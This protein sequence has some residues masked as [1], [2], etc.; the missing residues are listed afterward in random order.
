MDHVPGVTDDRLSEWVQELES[1]VVECSDIPM[2]VIRSIRYYLS[3][4]VSVVVQELRCPGFNARIY[5]TQAAWHPKLQQW[6][7][8]AATATTQYN[9]VFHCSRVLVQWDGTKNS[10]CQRFAGQWEDHSGD[11]P[12]SYPSGGWHRHADGLVS[13]SH[14][15]FT[16]IQSICIDHLTGDVWVADEH[17]IRCVQ[18]GRLITVIGTDLRG[19]RDGNA[20]EALFHSPDHLYMVQHTGDLYVWDQQKR[21]RLLTRPCRDS[22]EHV[23]VHTLWLPVAQR[24][25]WLSVNETQLILQHRDM[26][27]CDRLCFVQIGDGSYEVKKTKNMFVPMINVT[28]ASCILNLNSHSTLCTI[29]SRSAASLVDMEMET[30]TPIVDID[31]EP[32]LYHW[33]RRCPIVSLLSD[34]HRTQNNCH[35]LLLFCL[36]TSIPSILA[37]EL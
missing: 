10:E 13:E 23:T 36:D 5:P 15:R 33:L 29:C 31:V 9:V 18:H 20:S 17:R 3:L 35:R 25:F 34:N 30:I 2:E 12:V 4:R 1:V 28:S 16:E 21:V 24:R 22:L 11:P 6:I 27:G 14:T 8:A 26:N 19:S 7:I 37:I 32:D